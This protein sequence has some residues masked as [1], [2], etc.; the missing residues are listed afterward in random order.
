MN[1]IENICPVCKHSNEPNATV[2]QQCGFSLKDPLSSPDS[3][4]KRTDLPAGIL[5][6]LQDWSVDEAVVPKNGLAIY[7]ESKISPVR[8]DSSE[9]IILG[10]KSGKTAELTDR[11]FD[12]SPLGGYGHGVSRRHAV[13]LR[14][15]DGYVIVDLGSANG[16]WLNE[17]RLSPQQHYP[18]ESGSYIRLGGMR[19]FV[20][21]QIAK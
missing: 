15:E 1:V 21:Y 6:G 5:E 13:I 18:F 19:L 17:K 2:C 16:T 3:R 20:L 9:E 7:M 14:T 4:T 11:L 8:V 12:L 10:R